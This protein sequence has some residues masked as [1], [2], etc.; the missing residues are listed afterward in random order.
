MFRYSST[1]QVKYLIK[2]VVHLLKELYHRRV[3]IQ[4]CLQIDLESYEWGL[5]GCQRNAVGRGFTSRLSHAQ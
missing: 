3:F 5:S 1:I 4:V 2:I